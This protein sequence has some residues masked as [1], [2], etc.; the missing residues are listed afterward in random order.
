MNK[1]Y[2]SVRDFLA[3]I[4]L[5]LAVSGCSEFLVNGPEVNRNMEDFSA[6]DNLVRSR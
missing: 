5:C 4:L 6:V 1:T 2:V 3:S